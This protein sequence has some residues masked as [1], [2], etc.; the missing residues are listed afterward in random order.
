MGV[1]SQEHMMDATEHVKRD[2]VR[3]FR[4]YKA[5]THSLHVGP[6]GTHLRGYNGP[7]KDALQPAI[8]E[9]VTE[10][11]LARH[12][13]KIALTEQGKQAILS[14]NIAK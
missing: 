3:F 5:P 13:S 11:L 8:D 10:G 14:S 9:M 6:L 1:V 4:A 2:L 7:W 12:G